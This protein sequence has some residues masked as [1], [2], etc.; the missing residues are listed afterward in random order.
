MLVLKRRPRA[1]EN[2]AASFFQGSPLEE[3]KRGRDGSVSEEA[4][5]APPGSQPGGLIL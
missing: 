3:R 1:V 5:A 2:G 4:D